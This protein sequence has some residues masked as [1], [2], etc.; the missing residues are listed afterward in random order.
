LRE[1][2]SELPGI[3]SVQYCHNT[4]G[5]HKLLYKKKL[6]DRV[7]VWGKWGDVTPLPLPLLQLAY[8]MYSEDIYVRHCLF[9]I[10]IL[11]SAECKRLFTE[12]KAYSFCQFV[13]WAHC[14]TIYEESHFQ[15]QCNVQ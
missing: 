14:T 2:Q 12:V 10:V 3:I 4:I 6:G 11:K 15:K 7:Q 8:E 9:M 5:R 13:Q 1:E